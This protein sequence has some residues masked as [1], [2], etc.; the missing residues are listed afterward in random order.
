V[1]LCCNYQ[2]ERRLGT[3]WEQAGNTVL[4]AGWEEL[5]AVPGWHSW[6]VSVRSCSCIISKGQSFT[7]TMSLKRCQH[8]A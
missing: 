7:A 6:P 1:L 4:F 2:T 5:S 3:G 8:R